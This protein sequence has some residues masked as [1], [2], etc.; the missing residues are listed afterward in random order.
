[1]KFVSSL[2]TDDTEIGKIFLENNLIIWSKNHEHILSFCAL[3]FSFLEFS[4]KKKSKGKK[5]A[6]LD[7]FQNTMHKNKNLEST[8]KCPTIRK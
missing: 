2:F 1:M 4:L 3:E 6:M 5:Y 7:G 8:Y